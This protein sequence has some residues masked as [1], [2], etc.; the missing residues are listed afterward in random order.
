TITDENGTDGSLNATGGT[1][2]AGIGGGYKGDG[3]NITITGGEVTAQGGD[4]GA[5]IGGGQVGDG[6][7][8]TITGGEVTAQGGIWGAGIGGGIRGTG[9]D[10]TISGGEVNATGGNYAAGI[11]GGDG[12]D[13]SNIT[14]SGGN[15]TA[16]G[17]DAPLSEDSL[18]KTEGGG[19]GIGG[20]NYGTG[21]DITI[22][23]GAVV[24]A[25]GKDN[26]ADIGDGHPEDSTGK[27]PDN[28]DVSGL[29]TT[30]SVNGVPG[31]VDPAAQPVVFDG[32]N[33]TDFWEKVVRQI[34]A[35][36]P[37]DTI[38]IDA[39]GLFTIPYWVIDAVVEQGVTLVIQWTGG[40][41]I[42]IDHRPDTG[43]QIIWVFSFTTLPQLLAK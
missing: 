16:V 12:G 27:Q 28:V 33:E 37:G 4:S 1:D 38:T 14:I 36:N 3:S 43:D 41:D 10:I 9:S 40:E 42:V 22:K 11:G 23:N 24:T 7:N 31:T 30:G 18:E 29:Y 34:Q 2:A 13:G 6:S 15:V 25:E 17:G 21:S 20:G 19:S 32:L 35:A 26:A 8:I 5:G 39:S